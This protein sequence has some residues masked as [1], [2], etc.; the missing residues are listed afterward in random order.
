MAH[1]TYLNYD[2]NN[3]LNYKLVDLQKLKKMNTEDKAFVDCRLQEDRFKDLRT[4]QLSKIFDK[5]ANV[6]F[7]FNLG[8]FIS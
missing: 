1:P 2:F 5:I 6:K 3:F 4:K 8:N 7:V